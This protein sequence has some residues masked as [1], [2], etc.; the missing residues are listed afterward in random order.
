MARTKT[1]AARNDSKGRLKVARKRPQC[2]LINTRWKKVGQDG[3]KEGGEGLMTT[4]S[5]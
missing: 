1:R 5:R 2:L 4:R 3:D